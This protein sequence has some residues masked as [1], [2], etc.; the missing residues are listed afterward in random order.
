MKNK[1]RIESN[2]DRAFPL[3][4]KKILAPT[5]FSPNADQALAYALD[6]ARRHGAEVHLMHVIGPLEGDAYSPL[7]YS[8]E[9]NVQHDTPDKIAYD[10]LQSHIQKHDTKGVTVEPVKQHGSAVASMLLQYAKKEGID[11]IVMGTHG[12]QGMSRF[13]IGSVAERVVRQAPCSVMTVCEKETASRRGAAPDKFDIQRLL[14]PLDF[15]DQSESLLRSAQALAIAYGAQLDLL[16]VIEQPLFIGML[17]GVMTAND[18]VPNIAKRA[19]NELQRL[20]EQVDGGDIRAKLHVE[21]GHAAA[22]ITD[23][24]ARFG[25]DLIVIASQGRSGIEHFLI[26]SVAER[27]VRTARCPVLTL[28]P[29]GAEV[30]LQKVQAEGEPARTLSEDLG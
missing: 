6:L 24:A 14:V 1:S 3:S 30:S 4:L 5:D 26:G 25:T 22:H 19:E 12:R 20:W 18:L 13:I 21:E 23:F 15:S 16:H 29:V 10:L 17:S 8:P 11:L 28:K 9:A 27:V 7:R 2:K